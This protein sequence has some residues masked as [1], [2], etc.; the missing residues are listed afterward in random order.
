MEM[1]LWKGAGLRPDKESWYIQT[2]Q[3]MI[4]TINIAGQN[5]MPIP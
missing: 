1:D 2:G 3:G 4:N 5:E